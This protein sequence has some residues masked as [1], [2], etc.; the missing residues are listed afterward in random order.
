MPNPTYRGKTRWKWSVATDTNLVPIRCVTEGAN[1]NYSI[2][3]A[4]TLYDVWKRGLLSEIETLWLYRV[5]TPTS[6]APASLNSHHRRRD[7]Q[8]TQT[9]VYQEI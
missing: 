5:M 7:R 1:R 2:L 6:P 9:V 3:L 4:P 8:E